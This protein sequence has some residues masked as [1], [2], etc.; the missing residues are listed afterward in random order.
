M[1]MNDQLE[2]QK[3]LSKLLDTLGDNIRHRVGNHLI[4]RDEQTWLDPNWYTSNRL[5]TTIQNHFQVARGL[6][7]GSHRGLKGKA[8]F[9]YG[10]GFF[11]AE[12]QTR[13]I[14]ELHQFAVNGDMGD[15]EHSFAVLMEYERTLMSIAVLRAFWSAIDDILDRNGFNPDD[16]ELW[17]QT[18]KLNNTITHAREFQRDSYEACIQALNLVD[19]M[20][21]RVAQGMPLIDISNVLLRLPA[22]LELE[23][24][25]NLPAYSDP[26]PAQVI[27][28]K[29]G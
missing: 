15:P 18:A 5:T 13:M 4:R 1:L 20:M 28:A 16:A 29:F 19:E 27:H 14:D 21:N 22:E 24:R 6:R 8:L 12:E 7:Q 9:D 23:I 25:R 26:E 10:I 2:R 11:A 17:P 3:T